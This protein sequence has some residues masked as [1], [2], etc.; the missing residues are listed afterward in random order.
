MFKSNFVNFDLCPLPLVISMGGAEE[1]VALSSLL[2][3]KYLM[4]FK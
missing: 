4:T 3:S 2:Y 1:S